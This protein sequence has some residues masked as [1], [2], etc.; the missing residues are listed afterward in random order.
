MR[1][2]VAIT[3]KGKFFKSFKSMIIAAKEFNTT[4]T[5]IFTAVNKIS[6]SSHNYIWFY[7]EYYDSL[8]EEKIKS[9]LLN[10]NLNKCYYTANG[11][12]IKI[13][14]YNKKGEILN[15]FKSMSEA[16]KFIGCTRERIRQACNDGSRVKNYYRFRIIK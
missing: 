4:P 14:S 1:E 2:V 16:A 13:E 12:G 7:K 5:S 10:I 6:K 15:Q 8:T 3:K 11:E 9:I